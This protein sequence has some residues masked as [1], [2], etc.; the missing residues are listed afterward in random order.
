[1]NFIERASIII[2]TQLIISCPEILVNS[3]INPNLSVF[4][5]STIILFL[6]LLVC[7]FLFT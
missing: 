3:I 5:Y 6:F 2:F 4:F 7:L 1:M